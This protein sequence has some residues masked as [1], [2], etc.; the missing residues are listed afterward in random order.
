MI[1]TETSFVQLVTEEK[2]PV[3]IK[4]QAADVIKFFEV[5]ECV[6]VLQGMHAGQAGQVVDIVRP[7]GT[8]AVVLMDH[9]CVEQKV[10]ISNLRR[11]E[12]LDPHCKHSLSEFLV[13]GHSA[14]VKERGQTVKE[15]YSVGDLVVFN[16]H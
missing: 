2:V 3:P 16:D 6:R 10:L 11:K 12:E 4:V 5:G 13:Q 14:T 15:V 1:N 7:E 8:H 9:T